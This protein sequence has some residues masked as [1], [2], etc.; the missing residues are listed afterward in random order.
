MHF[1]ARV[2]SAGL[3]E[4]D[5]T[6]PGTVFQIGLPPYRID[7]LTEISGVPFEEAWATREQAQLESTTV[8]FI[9]REAFVRNKIASG[10]PKDLADAQR[11]EPKK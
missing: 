8:S 11:L 7:L 1:G 3:T 6:T 10:R 9:G 2:A 4:K 5:L